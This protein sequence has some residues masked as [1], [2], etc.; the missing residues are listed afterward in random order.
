M[1][2]GTS[3]REMAGPGPVDRG[4]QPVLP[5]VAFGVSWNKILKGRKREFTQLL[6][7]WKTFKSPETE[8]TE[9][10][11][12]LTLPYF[13]SLPPGHGLS[14]NTQRESVKSPISRVAVFVLWKLISSGNFGVKGHLFLVWNCKLPDIQ[15]DVV[16]CVPFPSSQQV[17]GGSR[18]QRGP[19]SLPSFPQRAGCVKASRDM[20]ES[21]VLSGCIWRHTA[22]CKN[23][24]R[25]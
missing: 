5:P 18:A 20:T 10:S 8:S 22:V 23:K 17:R 13:T 3:H 14:T 2:S 6:D 15:K 25:Q 16:L 24:L 1:P 4:R 19:A 21:S 9:A 12:P 11:K 7:K